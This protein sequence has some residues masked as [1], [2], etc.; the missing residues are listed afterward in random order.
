MIDN[1][2][3]TLSYL[4]CFRETE[5][6]LGDGGGSEGL[7]FLPFLF[8]TKVFLLVGTIPQAPMAMVHFSPVTHVPTV[9]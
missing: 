9:S 5:N 8:V 3:R 2:G 6:S 1:A 4:S 7:F